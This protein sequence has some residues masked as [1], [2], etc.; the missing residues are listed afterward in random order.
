LVERCAARPLRNSVLDVAMRLEPESKTMRPWTLQKQVL[1]DA[2]DVLPAAVVTRQEERFSAGVGCRWIPALEIAPRSACPTR[3]GRTLVAASGTAR[4][5]PVQPCLLNALPR[6]PCSAAVGSLLV[7]T[8]G[9]VAAQPMCNGR[10]VRRTLSRPSASP[11]H[12]DAALS[13]ARFAPG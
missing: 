6:W 12:H 8:R 13:R 4:V 7:R 2:F 9:T 1:R 5:R 11:A 10:A 3:T